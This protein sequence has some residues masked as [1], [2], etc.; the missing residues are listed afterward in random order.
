MADKI[1]RELLAVNFTYS[2][3]S[4]ETVIPL[5]SGC[6]LYNTVI[7]AHWQFS[8]AWYLNPPASSLYYNGSQVKIAHREADRG[9]YG[10][11]IIAHM[12]NTW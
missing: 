6:T 3:D 2:T 10:K 7:L 12:S 11:L 5:P 9:R 1:Q 8:D 4:N